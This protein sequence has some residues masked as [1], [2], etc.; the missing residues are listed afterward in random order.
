MR[1]DLGRYRS[2]GLGQ[3][4]GSMD[5]AAASMEWARSI[6]GMIGS[7]VQ[8]GSERRIAEARAAAFA[9]AAP[10]IAVAGALIA[11]AFILRR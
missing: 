4:G 3:A 9:S 10:W 7:G 5:W 2:V 6:G 1:G 8:A 11:A